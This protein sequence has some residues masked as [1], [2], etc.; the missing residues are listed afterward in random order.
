DIALTRGLNC[1]GLEEFLFLLRNDVNK[2]SRY[3]GLLGSFG[4]SLTNIAFPSTRNTD[5]YDSYNSK[6]CE[7]KST[8]PQAS[9]RRTRRTA[10]ART[11]PSPS[12]LRPPP[13]T[14]PKISR[15]FSLILTP[16]NRKLSYPA[17]A[18]RKG[19][20]CVT[21]SSRR[22]THPLVGLRR[23]SPRT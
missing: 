17:I 14:T 5:S 1:I 22:S 21:T 7:A 12:P 18:N 4:S 16:P 11:A 23:S 15:I 9:H 2:L 19:S 8:Q 10:V 13:T 6:I 3:S 20:A